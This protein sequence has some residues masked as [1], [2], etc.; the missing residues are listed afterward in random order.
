[1]FP[2]QIWEL[3]EGGLV[4]DGTW[5]A[6]A[7][8]TPEAHLAQM[9]AVLGKLPE[10]LLARSKNRDQ[11]FDVEGMGGRMLSPKPH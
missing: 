6:N 1:M 10:P 9:M 3:A 11:Y 7:P 8:Y 2:N 4:F 5:T